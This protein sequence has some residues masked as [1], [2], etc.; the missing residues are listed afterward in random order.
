MNVVVTGSAGFLGSHIVDA[1]LARGDWVAG[2]DDFS[3]GNNITRHNRFNE[4]RGSLLDSSKIVG[5]PD[6]VIH[7]AALAYEGL[8]VFSPTMVTENI[9]VGTTQIAVSAINAGVQRFVNCSSM[10]RYGHGDRTGGRFREID[11]P[12]PVDP[13]G[14][15][16]LAAEGILNSLGAVHG[17]KVVH[18]VPHNI[19]GPR[20]KYDDPYRNVVSIMANRMLRGLPPIVYGDGEQTRCFSYIDDV[21]PIILRM[22]DDDIPHGEVFNIGPDDDDISISMLAYTIAKII[23]YKGDVVYTT[24]RPAEVKHALCNSDKIRRWFGFEQKTPTL[25]AIQKTIQWVRD[26]GPKE[27]D[28][29]LR[30]EIVSSKTP[31]TWKE[32]LM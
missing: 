17:M 16:K 11:T 23:G 24:G 28:Y 18:A 6:A 20:Q 14:C 13:Y 26:A 3:G 5:K 31:M 10:A 15:S 2:V 8:S 4:V 7:C 32:R 22:L 1:L 25:I 12:R 9:V 27:F 21:V 30:L 19:I 29:R